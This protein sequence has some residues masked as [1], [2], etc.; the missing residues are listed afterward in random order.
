MTANPPDAASVE[1]SSLEDLL[2]EAKSNGLRNWGRHEDA[3]R[4]A[5]QLAE[6][7]TTLTAQL[8]AERARALRWK[9]SIYREVVRFHREDHDALCLSLLNVGNRAE[10]LTTRLAA[11]EAERDALREANR[12][13]G[14]DDVPPTPP[15][16]EDFFIVAVRRAQS[17]KVW[18]YPAIYIRDF[19]LTYCGGEEREETGWF[20]AEANGEESSNYYPLLQ[21]GDELIGWREVPIHPL[22][23]RATLAPPAADGGAT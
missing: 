19:T 6:H 16:E 18:S 21:P 3:V 5:R 22:D 10:D 23:A 20:T 15:G 4:A 9:W 7:V 8:E 17:G 12:W 11:V 2:R 14:P 13:H 1:D